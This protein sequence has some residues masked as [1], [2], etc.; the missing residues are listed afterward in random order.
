MSNMKC[1]VIRDGYTFDGDTNAT[2][3]CPAIKF[4]FRPCTHLDKA[5]W[6]ESE[7]E[8]DESYVKRAEAQLDLLEKHIVSWDAKE[9]TEDG[10]VMDSPVTRESL[11]GLPSDPFQMLLLIVVDREGR[12]AKIRKSNDEKDSLDEQEKN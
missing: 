9:F 10:K 12:T 2:E 6:I 7:S 3:T 8:A 11:A 1:A 4:K 5:Q